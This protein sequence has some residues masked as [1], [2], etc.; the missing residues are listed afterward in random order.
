MDTHPPPWTHLYLPHPPTYLPSAIPATLWR[1]SPRRIHIHLS[2]QPTLPTNTSSTQLPTYQPPPRRLPAAFQQQPPRLGT[3]DRCAPPRPPPYLPPIHI[4]TY[5][6]ATHADIR[7]ATAAVAGRGGHAPR[8]G[9]P[10]P[11]THPLTYLPIGSLLATV[12]TAHPTMAAAADMRPTAPSCP[13]HTI[14]PLTYLPIS[15]GPSRRPRRPS[16]ECGAISS[17]SW[18]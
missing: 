16:H 12:P 15:H 3:M 9:L 10:L 4:P 7:P 18:S 13:L 11:A 5:L 1:R 17:S 14:F 2:R 6:S 8:P